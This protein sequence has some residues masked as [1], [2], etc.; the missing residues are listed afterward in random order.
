MTIWLTFTSGCLPQNRTTEGD[1]HSEAT[2]EV[3]PMV[4]VSPVWRSRMV[5]RLSEIL[6]NDEARVSNS[7]SPSSVS[8]TPRC[9]RW[10]SGA[11]SSASSAFTWWLTAPGVTDS[12]C[13]AF[14]KLRCR[15]AASNAARVVS[16]GRL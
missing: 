3:E 2:A 7:A 14:L 10:N 5:L 8:S 15:A 11:C 9:L 1:S 4:T 13:A 6:E 12:S 16:G